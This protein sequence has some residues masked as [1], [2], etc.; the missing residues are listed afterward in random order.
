MCL[1]EKQEALAVSLLRVDLVQQQQPDAKTTA[2]VIQVMILP[3]LLELPIRL[4][5]LEYR[6]NPND[7]HNNKL[8]CH[9]KS[10][11]K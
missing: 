10:Q 1:S 11:E 8:F 5:F 3:L 6:S 2:F 9:E 7:T 4:Q